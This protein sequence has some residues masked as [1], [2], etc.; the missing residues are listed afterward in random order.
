MREPQPGDIPAEENVGLTGQWDSPYRFVIGGLTLLFNV[1]I[2]LSFFAV[3]PVTPLIIDDYGINRSA[4][5]LLTGLV[6][7]MQAAATIPGSMLIGRVPLKWLIAIAWF[8]SGAMGLSFLATSFPILL[9]LRVFYGLSFAIGVPAMGPLL[10]QWFRPREL[11]LVNGINLSAVAGAIALSTFTAAPL[12][13]V[14][15]WKVAQSFFGIVS[16]VGAGLWMILGRVDKPIQESRQLLS[17]KEAWG[18]LRS[19]VTLLLAIA[20]AG[21]FAQYVALSAWLP[22]FYFEVHNMSLTQ[23]GTAVGL[24]PTTGAVTV[25]VAG[26]LAL[27]IRNRR[28]FLIISG[29]LAVV[30]GF[31][32]ILLG[33]TIAIYLSLILLG[34]GSWLYLP[35]LFTIPMERPGMS[36]ESVAFVWG[37]IISFGSALSFAAP[38]VVGALTDRLG[39]YIPGFSI[40]AVLTA[41]LI[42]AGFLLPETGRGAD[43]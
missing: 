22:T 35:I 37:T 12:A 27:R 14:V 7:L 6:L 43:Q 8:L 33:G 18:L 25:L 24:L 19:R 20:D 11:P 21:P 5:S 13:G 38:L 26:M 42:I 4:A 15:G 29:I 39:T 41:S 16:L 32:S 3:A 28:P 9:I 23:A 40:F 34:V 2:G 17:L 1:S 36:P 10:M 30:A 31:G